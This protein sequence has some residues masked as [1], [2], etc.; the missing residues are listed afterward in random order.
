MRTLGIERAAS[1]GG[2]FLYLAGTPVAFLDCQSRE[3]LVI[4]Q[5]YPTA[6]GVRGIP[7]GPTAQ[8]AGANV[9]KGLEIAPA[10]LFLVAS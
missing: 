6:R 5:A 2:P 10:F 1:D 4:R 7:P 3:K 8:R 9:Q